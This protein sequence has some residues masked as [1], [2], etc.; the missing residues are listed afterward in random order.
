[1]KLGIVVLDASVGMSSCS[2]EILTIGYLLLAIGYESL[3]A[4][5]R[6]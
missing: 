6:P 3:L 5:A 4:G 1:M 2:S